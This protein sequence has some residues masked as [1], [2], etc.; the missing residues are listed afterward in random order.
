MKIKRFEFNM[1]PVNCYVL[2]DETNEA[3]IIDPGCF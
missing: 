1:F 2:S 3:V